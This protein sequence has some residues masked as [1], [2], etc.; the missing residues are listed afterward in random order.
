MRHEYFPQTLDF[1]QNFRRV[2]DGFFR[3]K[4]VAL[5]RRGLVKGCEEEITDPVGKKTLD[6]HERGTSKG[7]NM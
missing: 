6:D 4:A 1:P 5:R 7:R 3:H 2:N